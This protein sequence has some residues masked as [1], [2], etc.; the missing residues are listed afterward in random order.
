MGPVH[1]AGIILPLALVAQWIEH[2]LAELGVGG[3]SPLE[4][5]NISSQRTL[6]PPDAFCNNIARMGS[7]SSKIGVWASAVCAVHCA[8]TGILVAAAPLLVPNWIHDLRVEGLLL[9]VTLFFGGYT[10]FIG[11]RRHGR[12]WPS[13]VFLAG[14]AAVLAS[15]WLAHG[16]GEHHHVTPIE[17]T[18]SVLGGMALVGFFLVNARLT[19]RCQCP[20][21]SPANGSATAD[22]GVARL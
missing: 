20:A 9:S 16:H 8:A 21:C 18:V 19:A 12:V 11:W 22:S 1:L 3:S 5:A 15:S 7:G 14:F 13:L 6:R 2:Q 10:A 17:A 4:R